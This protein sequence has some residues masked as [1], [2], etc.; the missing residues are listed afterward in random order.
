MLKNSIKLT[1]F[2]TCLVYASHAMEDDAEEFA[3]DAE[4]SDWV[5]IDDED[6]LQLK[7]LLEQRKWV[8]RWAINHGQPKVIKKLLDKDSREKKLEKTKKKFICKHGKKY[9]LETA[10]SQDNL[11]F[12][13]DLLSKA[14][15]ISFKAD[16]FALAAYNGKRKITEYLASANPKLFD[17]NTLH[18]LYDLFLKSIKDKS[19]RPIKIV[20]NS[21]LNIEPKQWRK[22][23]EFGVQEAEKEKFVKCSDYLRDKRKNLPEMKGDPVLSEQPVFHTI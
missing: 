14:D 18:I 23:I 2:F 13:K 20:F 7:Q 19:L 12:V 10:I 16:A 11:N 6:E 4:T 1:I 5:L 3:I 21:S 22:L 9:A 15:D 8:L 17:I